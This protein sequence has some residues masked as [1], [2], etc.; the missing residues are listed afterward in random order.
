M[1]RKKD[2][3]K[4]VFLVMG[5]SVGGDPL[6]PI[7]ALSWDSTK[8]VE[9]IKS[10]VDRANKQLPPKVSKDDGT[11]KPTDPPVKD[12]PGPSDPVLSEVKL[13]SGQITMINKMA[14]YIFDLMLAG[15]LYLGTL[16]NLGPAHHFSRVLRRGRKR[17]FNAK[18]EAWIGLKFRNL[19][20]ILGVFLMVVGII[21]PTATKANF[22][23]PLTAMYA[24]WCSKLGGH[25][26]DVEP[27]ETATERPG[28]W[29]TVYQCTWLAPK[30]A[31][32]E[33]GFKFEFCL[34]TS[35]GGCDFD[36]DVA[37]VDL[38][39]RW[40]LRSER[41]DMLREAGAFDAKKY[42]KAGKLVDPKPVGNTGWG[43]CGEAYP[44]ATMFRE[45][46]DWQHVSGLAITRSFFVRTG[47]YS[48]P[49]M[50]GPCRNCQYM[51]KKRWNKEYATIRKRWDPRENMT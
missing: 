33:G 10:V 8:I 5:L 17:A 20:D 47:P 18:E 40:R 45:V 37:G 43:N 29:P 9:W 35:F 19:Y 46:S 25:A 16:G 41:V 2:P 22:F 4:P 15:K 6:N 13:D 48:L 27:N 30:T 28:P 51:L 32:T 38:D 11:T 39:W 49:E 24:K 21:Q 3:A 1:D 26:D 14:E 12:P 34:G 31:R 36:R 44:F 50:I 42:N 7:E 23:V